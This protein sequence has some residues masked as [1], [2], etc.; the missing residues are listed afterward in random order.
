MFIFKLIHKYYLGDPLG[1]YNLSPQMYGHMTHMLSSLAG[2]KIILSLEASFSWRYI[3]SAEFKLTVFI[4]A[5][6]IQ[7]K[8]NC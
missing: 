7:F 4:F 6:W 2:G 5:G 8:I 1:E 3:Q